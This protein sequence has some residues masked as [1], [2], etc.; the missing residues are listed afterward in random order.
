MAT[1]SP[2]DK[3]NSTSPSSIQMNYQAGAY[4]RKIFRGGNCINRGKQNFRGGKFS[5]NLK[6]PQN[7]K[8]FDHFYQNLGVAKVAKVAV[9]YA[10]VH[11]FR[12]TNGFF[13]F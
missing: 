11:G 6:N 10:S 1:T 5:Q 4:D 8:D 2:S 3:S 13:I 7:F 12:C 9:I